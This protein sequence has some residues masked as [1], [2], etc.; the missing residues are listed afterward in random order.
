MVEYG[1]LHQA[2][3]LSLVIIRTNILKFHGAKLNLKLPYLRKTHAVSIICL[4]SIIT[5]L[6]MLW[7]SM[8]SRNNLKSIRIRKRTQI[9][10]ITTLM[11]TI[12]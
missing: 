8:T 3:I 7:I 4:V 11:K 10:T 12:K 2:L 6:Y 5:L 9:L 1:T